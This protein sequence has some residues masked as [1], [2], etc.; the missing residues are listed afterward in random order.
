[1]NEPLRRNPRVSRGDLCDGGKRFGGGKSTRNFSGAALRSRCGKKVVAYDCEYT[2]KS[3]RAEKSEST[4]HNMDS[5][6]LAHLSNDL[7]STVSKD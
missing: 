1:M 3:K 2:S 4:K 5:F 7:E 6:V